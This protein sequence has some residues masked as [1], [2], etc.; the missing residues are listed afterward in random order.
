MRPFCSTI[1][2]QDQLES[3]RTSLKFNI[4]VVRWEENEVLQAID[5]YDPDII[6]IPENFIEDANAFWV[7][8]NFRNIFRG[9]H[10]SSTGRTSVI[11]L[12]IAVIHYSISV[13]WP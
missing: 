13:Y 2:F 10:I 7:S 1:V 12:I 8:P 5:N 3:L 4:T 11:P 6:I 9:G